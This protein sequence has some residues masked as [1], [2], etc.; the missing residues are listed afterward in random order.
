MR[1]PSG[2]PDPQ[3]LAVSGI[4]G[5]EEGLIA[6]LGRPHDDEV[7]LFVLLALRIDVGLHAVGQQ[8]YELALVLGHGL[9]CKSIRARVNKVFMCFISRLDCLVCK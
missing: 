8:G 5:S 4:D 9:A 3:F 2:V 1:V 6:T 7:L